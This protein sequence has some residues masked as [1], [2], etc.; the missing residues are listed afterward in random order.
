MQAHLDQA[1]HNG[2]FQDCLKSEFSTL[3][4][5]WKVTVCFYT[6]LHYI[7]ALAEMKNIPIGTHHDT[8][9]GNID[10]DRQGALMPIN[11]Q[12]YSHYRN[13]QKY[14]E[15]ARY[16]GIA[17]LVTFEQLREADFRHCERHMGELKKYLKS[18][19]LPI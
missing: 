3:F 1:A 12:A 9:R 8:I 6:A 5:D 11:R 19:N 7:R 16:H 2:K 13:L 18:L 4:F 17:D 15:I 14:S 10:P